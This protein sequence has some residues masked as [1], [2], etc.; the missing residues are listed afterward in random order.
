MITFVKYLMCIFVFFHSLLSE[1]R[2][3][4]PD[5]E[6]FSVKWEE[7]HPEM[8]LKDKNES[9][10]YPKD[11]GEILQPHKLLK[12][13]RPMLV[14]LIRMKQN[15][16]TLKDRAKT[17]VEIRSAECLVCNK[18][19]DDPNRNLTILRHHLIS[20]Q[21]IERVKVIEQAIEKLNK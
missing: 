6:V 12:L 14:D 10:N 18:R 1:T 16:T 15:D 13:N 20:R 5:P 4:L 17:D 21:H 9:R 7:Y 2:L 8:V 19:L 3:A 11:I